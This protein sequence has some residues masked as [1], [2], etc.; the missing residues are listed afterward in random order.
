MIFYIFLAF[1]GKCGDRDTAQS[2][3]PRSWDDLVRLPQFT[4]W[5]CGAGVVLDTIFLK[6][7]FFVL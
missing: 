2:G 6:R 5:G 1:S 3:Q 7:A 4:Y